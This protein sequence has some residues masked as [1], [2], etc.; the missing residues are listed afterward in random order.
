MISRIFGFKQQILPWA[1]ISSVK[2]KFAL[3]IDSH[4]DKIEKI[5]IIGES[6]DLQYFSR[7]FTHCYARHD[8]WDVKRGEIDNWNWAAIISNHK[9]LYANDA[10]CRPRTCW[11]QSLSFRVW[12]FFLLNCAM[13]LC[14]L[15]NEPFS[16]SVD[17]GSEND[18]ILQVPYHYRL[19]FYLV[20]ELIYIFSDELNRGGKP[21]KKAHENW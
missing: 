18:K 19:N 6:E 11:C 15:H 7:H 3:W 17:A 10:C 16:Y 1:H 12:C 14:N 20:Y 21:W 9:I 8:M 2:S 4:L 13:N 5:K